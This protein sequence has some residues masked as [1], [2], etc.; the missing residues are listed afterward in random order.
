MIINLLTVAVVT[1]IVV[2]IFLK[3]FFWTMET[4]VKVLEKE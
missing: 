4:I 2:N 3:I 1:F